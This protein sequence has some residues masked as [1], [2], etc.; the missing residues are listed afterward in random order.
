VKPAGKPGQVARDK[1]LG[2]PPLGFPTCPEDLLID[3]QRHPQRIDKAFSWDAPLAAHGMMHMVITNAAS[4]DPYPID[5][6]FM[7][8][9]N[10]AWN[11]TMNTPAVLDHVMAQD[12]ETGDYKIPKIIYSD[13]YF[14][15]MVQLMCALRHLALARTELAQATCGSIRLKLL[16]IG[17]QITVSVRRVKIALASSYPLQALFAH[18]HERLARSLPEAQLRR[19]AA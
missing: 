7:Y 8:M 2:G 4:A 15:E 6:L 18:A 14:S 12:E 16:K 3:D 17:A 1:P 13:A 10:M 5:V 9:A 11:S 19:P